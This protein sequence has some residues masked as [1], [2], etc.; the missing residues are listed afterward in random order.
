MEK[1]LLIVWNEMH[2]RL[3]NFVNSKVHDD[4]L[5]Q[6]IVQEVFIKVFSKIDTLKDKDKLVAWIFQITRNE[7]V[8]YFRQN[9]IQLPADELVEDNEVLEDEYLDEIINYVHP[10]IN[11]LPQ[12]YKEALVL[13]DIENISQKELAEK[14]QISYSGAKSRVQ[15]GR[16]LLKETFDKCCDIT[17]DVYGGVIDCKPKDPFNQ[18]D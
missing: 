12:K 3:L 18:C 17:T 15:R 11:V 2:E 8:S 4:D 9:K 5:S 6:D 16:K 1:E 14:L 7:I 10:M 13:S